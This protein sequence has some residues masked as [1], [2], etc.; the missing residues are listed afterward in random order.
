MPRE[1]TNLLEYE[2]FYKHIDFHVRYAYHAGSNGKLCFAAQPMET[3]TEFGDDYDYIYGVVYNNMQLQVGFKDFLI[4]ID[5]DLH[6][7]LGILYD[8]IREEFVM[9]VNTHL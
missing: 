7:R 2:R 9:L 4:I 3:F 6:K 8:L 1:N 5:N